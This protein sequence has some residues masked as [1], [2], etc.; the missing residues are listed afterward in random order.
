MQ[1][2]LFLIFNLFNFIFSC[3]LCFSTLIISSFL[4][5]SSMSK[6]ILFIHNHSHFWSYYF[7]IIVCYNYTY[8]KAKYHILYLL[9]AR[10]CL[11]HPPPPKLVSISLS[12]WVSFIWCL[13]KDKHAT[14]KNKGNT[15]NKSNSFSNTEFLPCLSSKLHRL[16]RNKASA[17]LVFGKHSNNSNICQL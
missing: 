16:M 1:I 5:R 12:S 15:V 17:F 8:Y 9:R 6:C 3:C 7:I 14:R 10:N 11:P 4:S 2:L 13:G